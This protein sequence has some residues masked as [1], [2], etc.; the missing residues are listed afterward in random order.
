MPVIKGGQKIIP[1]PFVSITK[2]IERSPD[3][4]V[5]KITFVITLKGK[6]SAYKGSPDSHGVLWTQ[7]GYPPDEDIPAVSRLG[8]IERKQGALTVLLSTEG[9]WLEIQS[10]DGTA[11]IKALVRLRNVNFEEGNWVEVCNYTAQFEAD[12]LYF[13]NLVLTGVSS[14]TP[15]ESWS[16]EQADDK[17]R[18]YRISHTISSTQKA[19]YDDN[20]NLVVTGWE[21]ARGVVLRGLGLDPAVY[22][23]N[24]PADLQGEGMQ[25]YNYVRAHQIDET[26]GK[27]TGTE[28][29]L[30][31]NPAVTGGLPCLEEYTINTRIAEDGKTRIS[32][33]GTITGL[34]VRD[35]NWDIVST[36]YNNALARWEQ[37]DPNIF[38]ICQGS[39]SVTLHPVA[40]SSAVGKNPVTG[41]ITFNR[42][43]DNRPNYVLNAISTTIQVA[44]KFPSDVY[45]QI[46]IL[47]KL[48]GP[49]FQAIDTITETS[50]T[51]SI[52][53]VM[54]A[55]TWDNPLP[56]APNVEN[57]VLLYSI[58]G[59][60]QRSDQN[61][62]AATGRYSR[63]V[64]W[65]I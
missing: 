37:L 56:T 25:P 52:E 64:T 6:I 35:A 39:A 63:T 41:V 58:G 3:N 21:V 36:R 33:E 48:S 31:Y 8:A 34:E 24:N 27:Y 50:R 38:A 18:T 55:A 28:T 43:F 5:R 16:V 17:G 11:P 45:A 42:E 62:V 19:I 1:A 22:D 13:G 14:Q 59:F 10:D 61:W 2:E 4:V 32:M 54:P 12:T 53:V 20:G 46:T 29:W 23:S 7:S 30:M 57:I 51:L 40:L 60:V 15:E 47:G 65:V 49:L 44:D 26:A 9:Q